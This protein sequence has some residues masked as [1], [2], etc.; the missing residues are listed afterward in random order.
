VEGTD[1]FTAAGVVVVLA[2]AFLTGVAVDDVVVFGWEAAG[3]AFLTGVAALDVAVDVVLATVEG[4]FFT[5]CEPLCAT[6]WMFP[7]LDCSAAF[8]CLS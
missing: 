4:V 5:F 2:G 6:F 8:C 1:F 7:T 3:V